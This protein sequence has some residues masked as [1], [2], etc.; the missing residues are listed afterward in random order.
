MVRKARERYE[1]Y[2]LEILET[3]PDFRLFVS[4]EAYC[5]PGPPKIEEDLVDSLGGPMDLVYVRPGYQKVY[6]ASCFV[7]RKVIEL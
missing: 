3:G 6:F 4:N 2:K 1:Q 5:K 7:F